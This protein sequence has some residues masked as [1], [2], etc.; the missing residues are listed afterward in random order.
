MTID[1]S[2]GIIYGLGID[3]GGTYTDAAI[4]DLRTKKVLFKAKARTTHHQLSIGLGEAIDNV[5]DAFGSR[6][7]DPSL[8]GVSTTLA[9]N[10]ILEGKG[11]QVG[12]I[13]LG[14]KPQDGWDLGAS[15]QRFVGGGHDVRGRSVG[16]LDV[17]GIEAAARD[18]KG[19]V[20]SVVVSGLFSVH[21]P[22]HEIE[23]GK[24]VGQRH[25]IPTV[26]AHQLTG[27]LGI[28]ERTV[29]A[30]LNAR[31]IPVLQDFLSRVEGILADRQ[32]AAPVMVFKGDGTLMNMRTAMERPVD[33]ILSGPAASAM[34][35]GVLAG[36]DDCVV[37]D[38]GG[39]STDIAV[40]E[41]GVPKVT[42]EGSMVGQWRTRVEAVDMWTTALGGDSEVRA[43]RTTKLIIGPERVVPLCFASQE[44]PGLIAKMSALSEARFLIAPPQQHRLSPS[45]DRIVA[46]LRKNGPTTPGELKREMEDIILLDSHLRDLRA[47]GIVQ[48]IGLTPTDVL[49]AC[50]VFIRGDREASR[51]GVRLYASVL[52]IEDDELIQEVMR[53]VTARIADEVMHKLLSD[54]L[55]ALP[56]SPSFKGVMDLIT[57]RRCCPTISLKAQV[58]RP[59]VGLGAPAR[60][61]ISPLAEILGARVIIPED[62]DVGNAVGA[63]C[64]QVSEFVDVFVY[65]REKGYAVFSSLNAP[66]PCGG[67]DEAV[68]K[69]KE[70][71]TRYA[72]ERARAAG[73]T[74]LVVDLR[75]EEERG[76][77]NSTLQSDELV[78]M[79]VR[80]RAVGRPSVEL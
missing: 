75:V 72:L 12:L 27:E 43:G 19:R 66:F 34:G 41:N 39:T 55:G 5:L 10:S 65:P 26:L 30:V 47:R 54:E 36:I 79:R 16:L 29:T 21:N 8:V 73:G 53:S 64:G 77:S 78:Q 40:L 22:Y 3:T 58:N 6:S 20:D 68:R 52:G 49:H 42:S 23:A 18:M 57:G 71:A 69:A 62:H 56:D 9:T 45:E 4:L 15:I 32:I 61:F 37:V 63:V 24:L 13:G 38:M 60:V 67:E 2:N 44:H 74:D 80:A 17:E 1:V 51:V 28:H 11:G 25:G 35:G 14:W 7:F 48:G 50:G 33:T 46:F 31:L 76:L 70:L 59:I